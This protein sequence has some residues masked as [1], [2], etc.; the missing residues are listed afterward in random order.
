MTM[1]HC[2]PGD[3]R[4]FRKIFKGSRATLRL[5]PNPRNIDRFGPFHHVRIEIG[6]KLVGR[7]A[8]GLGAGAKRAL[9]LL[10]HATPLLFRW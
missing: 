9:L 2:M 6:A 8:A 7:I 1:S 10:A 5:E 3:V 4:D